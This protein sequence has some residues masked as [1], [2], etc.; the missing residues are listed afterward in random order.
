MSQRLRAAYEE[1][2]RKGVYDHI[3]IN[4]D[5]EQAVGALLRILEGPRS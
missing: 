4:D 2:K 3:V 1:V 5:L